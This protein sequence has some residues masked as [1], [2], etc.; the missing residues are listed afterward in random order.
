MRLTILVLYTPQGLLNAYT[1][2][3]YYYRTAQLSDQGYYPFVNMWYE[4]LPPM[5]Y[6][7]ELAYRVAQSFAPM[8]GLDSVGYQL[9]ARLLGGIMLIFETGVV[10]LIH[11]IAE[12][13]WGLDTADRLGWIYSALSLPIF[14]WNASQ[15]SNI[16]FFTLLAIYWF[17]TDRWARSAVALSLGIWIKLTPV[18]LLAPIAKFLW[19]RWRAIIQYLLII[20]LV[21]VLIFVPFILLGGGPWIAASFASIFARASWSTPWAI[22]D[23]NWGVGDVGDLPARLQ[24][25]QATVIHGNPAVIPGF[26][27]IIVFAIIYWLIFLRP[28]HARASAESPKEFVW[29]STISLLLFLLWSKGWSPQWATLVIPFLLLS[30]PNQRGLKLILLLTLIVFLEWPLADALQSRALLAVS[31]IARTLLFIATSVMLIRELSAN[32]AASLPL[33]IPD[34]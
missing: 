18:F 15:T 14:F 10:I 2:Y 8:G 7:S 33:S 12:K 3:S 26:L 27:T 5:A 23:G 9:F 16:A 30:Y 29:L 22:I 20:A 25:D 21:S 11:R 31:I 4:H 28:T 24:L 19:T 34:E 1:D 6:T 32:S 13:T 17:I